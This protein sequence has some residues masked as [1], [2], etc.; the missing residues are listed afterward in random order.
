MSAD[1]TKLP[2]TDPTPILR[3]RDGVYAADLLT[4]AIVH[5]DFFTR[6]AAAPATLEEICDAFE[7]QPRPTDVLLTLCLCNGLVERRV[8]D[9]VFQVTDLAREHLVKGSPW[10]LTPYYQSLKDRPVVMDFLRVLKSGRPAQWSGF[11]D[12]EADWHG[13]MGDSDFASMF[14]GAMDCRGVYLGKALANQLD[15]LKNQRL[16]DIGGGSGIYACALAANFP[17]LAAT[18][19]ELPPVDGIARKAIAERGFSDR[20]TVTAG[21]MFEADAYPTDCDVHLFSNV[22]HD[23]DLPEIRQLLENSFR[24]LP[25]GGR[26]AVHE[27]FLNAEKTGP[28]P[29]AEYSCILM[30]STQGRCYSAAEM[31]SLLE[32]AGFHAPSF[33]VTGGDRGVIQAQ[34]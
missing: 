20:V 4:A 24:A 26:I 12:Q 14:T 34:K 3:Y 32:A 31:A 2:T 16:L 30:H 27:T 28:L 33:S 13:A 23:W 8:E 5:L 17:N 7:F 18:L 9:G 21:N 11:E 15:L 29:V 6:L 1:L 22:M 25:G 10:N 19:L